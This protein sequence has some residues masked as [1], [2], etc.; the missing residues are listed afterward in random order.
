MNPQAA[1]QMPMTGFK[2]AGDEAVWRWWSR[3]A[4]EH[5][6]AE[7][8][9]AEDKWRRA[10]KT[11]PNHK[12]EAVPVVNGNTIPAKSLSTFISFRIFAK[13]G[14]NFITLQR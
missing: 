12:T 2:T 3:K 4:A 9:M 11:C 6:T 10:Q 13:I 8:A 1:M 5:R 14:I 7:K